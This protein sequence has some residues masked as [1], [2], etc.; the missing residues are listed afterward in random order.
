MPSSK[1][2]QG[3]RT[4]CHLLLGSV[5]TPIPVLST[6]LFEAFSA[7]CGFGGQGPETF[8]EL[9]TLLCVSASYFLVCRL[10][11]FALQSPSYKDEKK[12]KKKK[13]E[14]TTRPGWRCPRGSFP[15]DPV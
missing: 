1:E 3:I 15:L 10:L 5:T 13:R 9:L 2:L 4:P 8:Q 6:F 14:I 7:A 11:L 12:R